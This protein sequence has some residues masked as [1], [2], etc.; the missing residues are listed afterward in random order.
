MLKDWVRAAERYKAAKQPG[1]KPRKK[2]PEPEKPPVTLASFLTNGEGAAALKLLKAAETH[3]CLGYSKAVMS[4][5]TS[6]ILDG[7]GL[8]KLSGLIGMAGAYSKEK[9][10]HEA[11]DPERAMKLLRDFPQEGN[12]LDTGDI[13]SEA[14]LVESIRRSLDAIAHDAP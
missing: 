11:I 1:F 7:D 5:V 12:L 4:R 10:E 6:V 3:I 13:F 14:S 8:K 2:R 9:P